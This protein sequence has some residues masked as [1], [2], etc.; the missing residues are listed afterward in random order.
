MK[1]KD[2]EKGEKYL[3][4]WGEKQ[5][6]I[7]II[8]EQIEDII[9]KDERYKIYM[10]KENITKGICEKLYE[11]IYKDMLTEKKQKLRY[12]IEQASDIDKII[13]R[14]EEYQKELLKLRYIY[15]KSWQY[16]AMHVH[17]SL[18]QCFNE[19]NFIISTI[20]NNT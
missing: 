8:Q 17:I 13:D 5:K 3:K 20:L 19:K 2:R 12:I 7:E 4:Q 9:K 15:K 16:I 10:N 18:R 11:D 1:Q 6:N 14:L